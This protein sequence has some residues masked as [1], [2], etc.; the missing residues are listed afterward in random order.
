MADALA[1]V[2]IG[3]ETKGGKVDKHADATPLG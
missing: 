1:V 3:Q 2:M